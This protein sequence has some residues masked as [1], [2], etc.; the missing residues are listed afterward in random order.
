MSP[1]NVTKLLTLLGAKHVSATK[2]G[3][4]VVS[5]CPLGPWRHEGGESSNE[6]FGVKREPGDSRC[7]C[8]SCGWHGKLSDLV[9]EMHGLN[10]VQPRIEAKW[11]E[12]KHLVE[13]AEAQSDLDFD[14]PDIEEMLFGP[15]AK[16]PE[17]P[18]WWLDSFPKAKAIGWASDYLKARDVPEWIWDALDLRA[19]TEEQRVCFPV[20]DFNATLRG[21]HGRAI[22]KETEPRY[23][24]YPF[25]K[26]TNPNIWLGESWVDLARPI[27]VVE[28]PFDLTSVL[29]VYDNVVS[30][31]F[32][33]PSLA[34]IKR[35]ADCLEWVTLFDHGT[36][37]DKGRQRVSQALSR[38]HVL[39]HLKP[40]KNRKDPG[41]CTAPE[42]AEILGDVVQLKGCDGV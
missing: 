26:K 33:N 21:L 27:V 5:N 12:A 18:Q 37:G 25:A 9:I 3:G 15:K 38:D 36:G 39:H 6:V 17:F 23:R 22:S 4:W 2:R 8:F 24:M 11:S 29:R 41:E 1:E 34:K 7:N 31:L 13:E 16:T 35:M 28:G 10:K 42:L 19:D 40:P 14:Y 32:A 20:R 30:P